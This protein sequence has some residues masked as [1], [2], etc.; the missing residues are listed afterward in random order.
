MKHVHGVDAKKD[1]LI[2]RYSDDDDPPWVWGRE[3]VVGWKDDPRVRRLAHVGYHVFHLLVNDPK[4]VTVNE[5][6]LQEWLGRLF[7]E[8]PREGHE[9]P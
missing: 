9:H 1:H 7:D 3:L 4:A 2:I 6:I 8:H 5:E